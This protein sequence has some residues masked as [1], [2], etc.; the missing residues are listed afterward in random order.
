M[1]IKEL[2]TINN[3][4]LKGKSFNAKIKPRIMP[5]KEDI[6]RAV[7]L[8]FNDKKIISKSNSSN[9]NIRTNALFMISTIFIIYIMI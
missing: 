5:V 3:K 7:K 2:M 9:E 1:P 8:T 4:F 6:S